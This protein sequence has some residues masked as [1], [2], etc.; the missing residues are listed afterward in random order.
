MIP[1]DGD[2]LQ[3]CMQPLHALMQPVARV[4]HEAA[5]A[6]CNRCAVRDASLQLRVA[7]TQP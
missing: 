2:I 1:H 6:D 3:P 5:P 7:A 4:A